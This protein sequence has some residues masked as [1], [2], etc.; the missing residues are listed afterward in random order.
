MQ[1]PVLGER[2]QAQGVGEHTA[3]PQAEVPSCF[4][5]QCHQPVLPASQRGRIAHL[6]SP[7]LVQE[8]RARS[9]WG[10]LL[11][12]TEHKRLRG[13][14]AAR[15]HALCYAEL[16]T[17]CTTRRAASAPAAARL[18]LPSTIAASHTLHPEVMNKSHR[19]HHPHQLLCGRA[20][21]KAPLEGE[22]Q[23][24][25]RPT[26][27]ALRAGNSSTWCKES[28]TARAAPHKDR[29]Q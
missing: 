26:T 20:A 7:F 19:P 27:P 11:H 9:D 18:T 22:A 24:E 13:C 21:T 14:W 29:S 5:S 23:H 1:D 25:P 10:R 8:M 3:G 4:P 12:N 16:P 15:A 28:T 17:R 2:T 6:A